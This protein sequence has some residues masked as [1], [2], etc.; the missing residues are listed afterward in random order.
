MNYYDI[1]KAIS[2]IV[3]R[4]T[5]LYQPQ[6]KVEIVREKGRKKNYSQFNLVSKEWLRQERLLKTSQIDSFL[7]I[8][9]RA[10]ACPMPFNADIYDSIQCPYRCIYCFASAFK[11][12]LYTS[13]FDNAK[14]LGIRHC[15]PDY[16]K[17]EIDKMMKYRSWSMDQKRTLTGINK[18]FALEMPVRFGIRYEDFL[19]M[20]ERLKVSLTLLQYF[21]DI[22]YP[23]M[24]N[25]K[26]ALVGQDEYVRALS[27]NP[28]RAA[29]HVTVITSNEEILKRLEPGAPPYT[30]RLQAIRNLTTAGVR[31]VARIEPFLFLLTDHPDD[32]Q[33]Y[34]E[35]MWNA[36]VRHITFD[37]YSYTAGNTGLRQAFFNAGYDYDR[38]YIAGCDSQPLGSVLL[39]EFMKMFRQRGFHC[40][41]FDM[42]NV[43]TND[44][45]ICCEVGDWFQSGWNYGCTVMAAR[46][47]TSQAGNSVTW[48]QFENWVEE[49]GG[50]LTPVLRNEV[51]ELWNLNGN[52]A[53]SHKWA[54]KLIPV[55]KDENGL[56]WKYDVQQ[57]DYRYQLLNNLI[58]YNI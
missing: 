42:G 24:I 15:N 20:E 33:R 4:T 36:G 25:T 13:F 30:S 9:C 55:G 48:A 19:R 7:E 10:A 45:D 26:S 31:V 39:G 34:M 50:F 43:P 18:A 56:I 12:S 32:V 6:R 29:V 49:H 53:Y 22:A 38:L 58:K 40:S 23:V 57:L 27:E 46:Y 54:S 16:Y 51:K 1:R 47:V 17:Q 5:T 41:T 44:Q 14:T 28:A 11:A 3:P 2:R 21:K 8:S 35:D 52:I 37:T